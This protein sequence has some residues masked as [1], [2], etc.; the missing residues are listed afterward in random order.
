MN[1]NSEKYPLKK[2]SLKA[3]SQILIYKDIPIEFEGNSIEFL[4]K[5]LY[6]NQN[7]LKNK[8]KLNVKN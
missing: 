2:Y 3:G 8:Y 4:T 6:S 1:K 5:G 7:I